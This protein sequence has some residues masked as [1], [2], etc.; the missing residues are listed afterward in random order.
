MYG[1]TE[2]IRI[3]YLPPEL[4]DSKPT[5]VG[6]AIPGTEAWVEDG[7]GNRAGPEEVGEL[8]V[9]G[10]H[11][12]GGYWGEPE[13]SAEK[14]R[15]GDRPG[16]RVLVTGDLFRSDEDGHL[17]FVGGRGDI[18]KSR[19]EKVAPREVEQVLETVP[20]VRAV[21]VV[22]I[23]DPLLGQAVEAH[24]EAEADAPDPEELR[25]HCA[26]RLEA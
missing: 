12:M 19:G 7:D 13:L 5:S 26:E 9:R 10:P 17:Y 18:I 22:G 21:A 23:P 25:R 2:C 1:Q 6:I 11:V 20:G 3:S 24:V 8:I 4:I 15:D 16:E 14:L